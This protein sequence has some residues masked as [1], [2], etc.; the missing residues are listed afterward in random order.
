[1]SL[2]KRPVRAVAGVAFSGLRGVMQVVSVERA[3]AL[4][5]GIGPQ[6]RG[7]YLAATT[8]RAMKPAHLNYLRLAKRTRQRAQ[9]R[10]AQSRAAAA[11]FAVCAALAL[12]T[13]A[14]GTP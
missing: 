7:R 9:A 13:V 11:L 5:F 14:S 2:V 8:A 3:E 6:L 12:I 1:M 4:C 10:R